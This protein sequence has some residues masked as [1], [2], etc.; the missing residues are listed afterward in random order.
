MTADAPEGAKAKVDE[1][2]KAINDGTIQIFKGPIKDQTGAVKIK[3]GEV[4]SDKDIW[5]M[6]WFVQGV[7]GKTK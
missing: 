5:N 7:I 6:D 2:K 4:M 1:T 3:E